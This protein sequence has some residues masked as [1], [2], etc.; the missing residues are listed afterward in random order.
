MQRYAVGCGFQAQNIA[1][2][3]DQGKAMLGARFADKGAVDIEKD[4][5]GG[6]LPV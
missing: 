2:G 3:L 6:Q 5:A 1:N 4:K